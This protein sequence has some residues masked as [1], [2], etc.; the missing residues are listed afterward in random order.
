[1]HATRKGKKAKR[2]S[3]WQGYIYISTKKNGIIGNG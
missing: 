2:Y 3:Q 1:M